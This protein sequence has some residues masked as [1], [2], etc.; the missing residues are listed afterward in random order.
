MG[1]V[2]LVRT[3][4]RDVVRIVH[5]MSILLSVLVGTDLVNLV[6]A[7]GLGQLVNPRSNESSD[8]FLGEGMAN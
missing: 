3:V 2:L 8:G 4:A 1:R 7:L 5:L 6:H